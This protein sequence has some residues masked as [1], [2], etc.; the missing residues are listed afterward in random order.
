[1]LMFQYNI[2]NGRKMVKYQK[3]FIYERNIITLILT[4][5]LNM[6][7][8]LYLFGAASCESA[9]KP[10]Q[11]KINTMLYYKIHRA[12]RIGNNFP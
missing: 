9:G 6:Q 5:D 12:A 4:S 7:K 3:N 2:E 11:H 10:E 8:F 1:M